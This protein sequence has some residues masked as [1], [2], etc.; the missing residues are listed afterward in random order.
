MPNKDEKL[1]AEGHRLTAE[2]V[3][4]RVGAILGDAER[5]AREIIDAARREG[6]Y[7]SLPPAGATLDD[8]THALDG[9]SARFDAFELATA[10]QIEE[11]GHQLRDALA[12][13]A[14]AA[15][16]QFEAGVALPPQALAPAQPESAEVAAAR[17]RA[18]DLALA[19]YSR[20]VIANELATSLER[21]EVE[22]LLA[23]VLVN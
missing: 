15:P 9:L 1:P 8:L 14:A 12:G 10:A 23:E 18:I 7:A 21:A 11:L 5:E 17:V 16:R 3:G 2:E 13:I 20:D 6:V 4:A 19:G 22:A